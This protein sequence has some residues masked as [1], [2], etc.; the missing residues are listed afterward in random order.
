MNC[1]EK[2]LQRNA[3]RL[4]K[5]GLWALALAVVTTAVYAGN[6]HNPPLIFT[7][8]SQYQDPSTL[9]PYNA[10]ILSDGQGDYVNGNGV[11]ADITT[12]NGSNTATLSPGTTRYVIF[13]FRNAVATNSNTPPWTSTPLLFV[14]ISNIL[15]NYNPTATYSFTTYLKTTL[16][17][18]TTATTL[19]GYFNLE[20]PNAVAPFNPPDSNI[21]TPCL[22][23]LVN[24]Q[25]IPATSSTKETW[26]AWPDSNPANSSCGGAVNG[27]PVQVGTLLVPSSS[28]KG[29]ESTVNAGQFTVPFYITIRRP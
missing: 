6:C 7:I 20:N 5:L 29:G 9:L 15:Y 26:I 3:V 16:K 4:T 19:N 23:S 10:G 13:D 11:V 17:A 18:T 24:V 2:R 1:L 8:S 12:C 28:H 25:H 27:T 14:S 21:N 22:T